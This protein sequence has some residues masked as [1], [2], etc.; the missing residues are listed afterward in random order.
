MTAIQA[1]PVASF[2]QLLLTTVVPIARCQDRA[3]PRLGMLKVP[4]A[5]VATLVPNHWSEKWTKA[6][7]MRKLA[8]LCHI[9][10]VVPCSTDFNNSTGHRHGMKGL[11]KPAGQTHQGTFNKISPTSHMPYAI[12]HIRTLQCQYTRIFVI[13]PTAKLFAA[14]NI[15]QVSGDY[16]WAFRTLQLD[17]WSL[18]ILTY[19]GEFPGLSG[20]LIHPTSKSFPGCCFP[21]HVKEII[22][23]QLPKYGKSHA[24]TCQLKLRSQ[25][26]V[27][28]NPPWGLIGRCH[29]FHSL[30]C[31][32]LVPWH[33]ERRE[34]MM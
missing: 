33:H 9:I 7:S 10:I 22:V 29:P 15:W 27:A 8:T 12:C 31:G 20:G 14:S 2:L 25:R 18:M 19:S 24:K 30:Q 16:V 1:L 13:F 21:Y 6:Q 34:Q 28:F 3:N 26:L 17:R 5:F 32:C 4:V 23:E 11:N